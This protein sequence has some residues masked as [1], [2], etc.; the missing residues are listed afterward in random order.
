MFIGCVHIPALF[1][2]PDQPLLDLMALE[3]E[4]PPEIGKEVKIYELGKNTE[5]QT[6]TP[7]RAELLHRIYFKNGQVRRRRGASFD[8][9]NI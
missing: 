3:D 7:L 4:P 6:V 9:S 8:F 2:I 1:F 5:T